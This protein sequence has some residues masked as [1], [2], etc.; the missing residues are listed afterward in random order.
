ML[1]Q[2]GVIFSLLIITALLSGIALLSMPGCNDNQADDGSA[3]NDEGQ[4]ASDDEEQDTSTENDG[5][6][7]N[8]YIPEQPY[9][10]LDSYLNRLVLAEERGEAEDF[11]QLRRIELLYDDA[12]LVS[13]EVEIE[14]VPGQVK[15]AT[16]VVGSYGTVGVIASRSMVVIVPITKLTALAKEESIDLI[17]RPEYAVGTE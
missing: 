4:N 6:H 16:E 3:E 14:C 9:P 10:K 8:L 1:K 15:A 12:G 5:S 7:P 11:A 13:V 17:R 2:A